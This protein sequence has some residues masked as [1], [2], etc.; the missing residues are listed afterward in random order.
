LTI[1]AEPKLAGYPAWKPDAGW[2]RFL[3]GAV[4]GN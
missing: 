2:V 1:D 3:I 4:I